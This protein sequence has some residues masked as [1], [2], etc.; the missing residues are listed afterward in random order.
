MKATRTLAATVAFALFLSGGAPLSSNAAPASPTVNY[1]FEGNNN[2]SGN[3]STFTAAPSCP[4]DP[5]NSSTSFG[6]EGDDGYLEW[7]S[8]NS[9]GGGFVVDTV[10]SLTNTYTILMKFSF[11]DFSSYRKII[12]YLDRTSDTGFYIYNSRI[13]FYDLGTSTN[14]FTAG[15]PMTLMVTRQATTGD[16]GVFTVYSYNGTTFNRE[17]QVTDTDGQSIP[18]TSTVHS[19]GTKLGFFF[20]D[21]DTSREATTSGKVFSLKMWSGVALSAGNLEDVATAPASG[22]GGSETP[23]PSL[24]NTGVRFNLAVL[25][26]GIALVGV[27]I[28]LRTRRRL[29]VDE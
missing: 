19:G 27:G 26:S 25:L 15:Q 4:A 21:L 2:D 6:T 1:T 11:T 24:A 7:A 20:D 22:G 18:A 17:L 8:T 28:Y 14:S 9:R 13:N 5:C 3:G 16:D 10:Q 12:D 23:D 29:A